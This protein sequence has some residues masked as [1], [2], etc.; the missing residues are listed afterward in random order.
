MESSFLD[1]K[2]DEAMDMVPPSGLE[3][4]LPSHLQIVRHVRALGLRKH[5]ILLIAQLC[6]FDVMLSAEMLEYCKGLSKSL[7]HLFPFISMARG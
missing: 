4:V 1:E 5:T 6:F 7:D 2:E 3:D